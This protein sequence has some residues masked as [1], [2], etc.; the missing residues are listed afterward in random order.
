MKKSLSSCALSLGV[1]FVMGFAGTS[2][3]ADGIVFVGPNH[4]IKI[5]PPLEV[6]SL[7]HHGSNS[8]ETGGVSVNGS[9]DAL[10]GDTSAGPHTLSVAFGRIGPTPRPLGSLM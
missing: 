2:V 9:K 5:V 7:Q 4:D 1:L 6:L 3:F 10:F 8:S